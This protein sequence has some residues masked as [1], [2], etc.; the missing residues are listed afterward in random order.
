MT[1]KVNRKVALAIIVI[2]ASL[3]MGVSGFTG[4]F[5]MIGLMRVLH[6]AL[7]SATNPLSIGIVADY[8]PPDKRS[9]ANSII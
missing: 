1:D 2:L 3:T 9:T 8:F 4:S 6:G 5:F 7:N